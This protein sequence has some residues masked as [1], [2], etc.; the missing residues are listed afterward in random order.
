MSAIDDMV[1]RFN[2]SLTRM[3]SAAESRHK[4]LLSQ[5]EETMSAISSAERRTTLLERQ[6]ETAKQLST[7]VEEVRQMRAECQR[8]IDAVPGEQ[9]SRLEEL[10]QRVELWEQVS[11]AWIRITDKQELR[12]HFSRLKEGVSTDCYITLD[13]SEGD[14]WEVKDCQ[15]TIPELQSLLD[16][17]NQSKDLGKFCRSVRNG[18]QK[19]V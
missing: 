11:G 17:L 19:H 1:E 6:L 4:S 18:F 14:I 15:P 8:Q 10:K 13:A 16:E 7:R 9:Q 2:S 5:R 3:E 12:F